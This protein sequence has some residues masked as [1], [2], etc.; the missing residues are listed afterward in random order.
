MSE[1][2]TILDAVVSVIQGLNLTLD[3]E[4]V[5]V[6][7]VKGHEHHDG[8]DDEVR[9]T[10]A[11]SAKPERYSR[12]SF[13]HKRIDFNVEVTIQSPNTGPKANLS[14]YALWQQRILDSFYGPSLPG[15]NSVFEV[16]SDAGEFLDRDKQHAQWDL[17][18]V[19]I[20][21]SITKPYGG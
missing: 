18:T 6:E 10:V 16:S 20:T 4:P 13:T 19:E 11:K 2:E 3:D 8:L 17:L 21:A 9:I 15:A 12:W 14:D 1:L 5:Y 7:R